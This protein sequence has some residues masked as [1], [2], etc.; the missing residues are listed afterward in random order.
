MSIV[1]DNYDFQRVPQYNSGDNLRRVSR[2][3]VAHTSTYE[4]ILFLQGKNWHPR[5]GFS[6]KIGNLYS[7]ERAK[8]QSLFDLQRCQHGA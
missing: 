6:Y 1:G 7:F 4:N 8:V 3:M 5:T 2:G